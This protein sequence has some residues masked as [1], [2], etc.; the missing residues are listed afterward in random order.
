MKEI[1]FTNHSRDDIYHPLFFL[2]NIFILLASH[3]H[4]DIISHRTKES[5][6]TKQEVINLFMSAVG[7][8]TSAIDKTAESNIQYKKSV[9]ALEDAVNL[10]YRNVDAKELGSNAE[11]RNAKVSEKTQDLIVAKR[12]AEYLLETARANESRIKAEV[13]QMKYIIR[14]LE[15]KE[16]A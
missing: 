4:D 6:M 1:I 12:E 15:A 2:S 3:I 7:Q 10:I 8:Y 14:A 5:E 9:Y 13:D 16:E 11:A